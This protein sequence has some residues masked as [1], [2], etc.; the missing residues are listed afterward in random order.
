MRIFFI[1]SLLGLSHTYTSLY[2]QFPNPIAINGHVNIDLAIKN[3][4]NIGTYYEYKIALDPS[5]IIF[6]DPYK[7]KSYKYKFALGFRTT[8]S[9]DY[10]QD[11]WWK[12]HVYN[13]GIYPLSRFYFPFGTFLE[14]YIGP[15]FFIVKRTNKRPDGLAALPHYRHMIWNYGLG[16]GHDFQITNRI[17]FEPIIGYRILKANE[18]YTIPR[19]VPPYVKEGPGFTF[20]FGFQFLIYKPELK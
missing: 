3:Q 20:L 5:V 19:G 4:N 11:Y 16:L 15:S 8:I 14:L 18:N 1:S 7:S 13:I 10:Y 2:G 6:L 17:R 12:Q 9:D